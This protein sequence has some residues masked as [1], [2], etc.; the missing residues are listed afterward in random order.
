MRMV[1]FVVQEQH[2]MAA[3]VHGIVIMIATIFVT[4]NLLRIHV[5]I[6]VVVMFSVNFL[7]EVIFVWMYLQVNVVNGNSLDSKNLYFV[8]VIRE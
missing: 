1:I 4:T 6:I 5:M 7:V 2:L 3:A 8:T